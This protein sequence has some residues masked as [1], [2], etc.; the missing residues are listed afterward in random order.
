MLNDI[1][2]MIQE[3]AMSSNDQKYKSDQI[4]SSLQN[5]NNLSQINATQS[6]ELS[7]S[8]EELKDH[9]K[10]LKDQIMFFKL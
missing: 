1:N 3:V 8:S 6:E 10:K 5:L 2:T 7:A 9:S 4:I